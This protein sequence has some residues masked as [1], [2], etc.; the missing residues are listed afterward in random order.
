MSTKKRLSILIS[1]I[2]CFIDQQKGE[3]TNE[4]IEQLEDTITVINAII[5]RKHHAKYQA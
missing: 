1:L 2:Y 5:R 3:I 4:Q